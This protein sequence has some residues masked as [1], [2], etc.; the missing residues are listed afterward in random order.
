MSVKMGEFVRL[1][2]HVAMA[3]TPA[4]CNPHAHLARLDADCLH[5]KHTERGCPLTDTLKALT[6][7]HAFGLGLADG[8]EELPLPS[9]RFSSV[10]RL[11]QL[12]EEA[13]FDKRGNQP[14]VSK[15]YRQ[16]HSPATLRVVSPQMD[17]A[18]SFVSNDARP[19]GGS[20]EN[21]EGEVVR[22]IALFEDASVPGG[23]FAHVQRYV[24][25][26]Y[27]ILGE[28]GHPSE[29]YRCDECT[30]VPLSAIIEAGVKVHDTSIWSK[31]M[32]NEVF[33]ALKSIAALHVAGAVSESMSDSTTSTGN[34]TEGLVSSAA[35]GNA[36]SIL[37]AQPT[38]LDE[39]SVREGETEEERTWRSLGGRV[40]LSASA[41]VSPDLLEEGKRSS[42]VQAKVYDLLTEHVH[43]KPRVTEYFCQKHYDMSNRWTDVPPAEEHVVSCGQTLRLARVLVPT[44]FG[45]DASPSLSASASSIHCPRGYVERTVVQISCPSCNV[46]RVAAASEVPRVIGPAL[47]SSTSLTA[48]SSSTSVAAAVTDDKLSYDVITLNGTLIARNAGVYIN[49]E[50]NKAK[51]YAAALSL[52]FH[53]RRSK[54][55]WEDE[56]SILAAKADERKRLN[57]QPEV[58]TELF[59]KLHHQRPA[60]AWDRTAPL[61]VMY[62]SEISR[63]MN[64]SSSVKRGLPLFE[65][66]GAP[67]YRPEYA[68]IPEAESRKYSF[69]ELFLSRK[70]EAIDDVDVDFVI[71]PCKIFRADNAPNSLLNELLVMPFAD[72]FFIRSAVDHAA[73]AASLLSVKLSSSAASSSTA[74]NT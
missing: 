24:S 65:L 20:A 35:A 36:T 23:G 40:P 8:A 64:Y 42:L 50:E 6:K 22:V 58:Y 70:C 38:A 10:E 63:N 69:H 43:K 5:D 51:A 68:P 25:S 46:K 12:E 13:L 60:K 72:V 7:N 54:M 26:L 44:S 30:T 53:F 1:P 74:D 48:S 41:I 47:P 71:G 61:Q 52:P 3:A 28:W 45:I 37:S 14:S 29:L 32:K 21:D 49:E 18:F 17:K 27:T 33:P 39:L 16:D 31:V 67:L 73:G 34:L 19:D 66:K 15:W 9:Q 57:E 11:R 62:V 56:K 59:R 2:V 4:D 55:D